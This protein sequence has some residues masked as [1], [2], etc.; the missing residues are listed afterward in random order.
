ML[1]AE[2]EGVFKPLS[3][4]VLLRS[5]VEG[6][7]AVGTKVKLGCRGLSS[8]PNERECAKLCSNILRCAAP[9]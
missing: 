8:P 1:V 7:R 4:S 9:L 3:T 5:A 6:M 2:H